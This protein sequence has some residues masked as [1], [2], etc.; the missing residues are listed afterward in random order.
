[1]LRYLRNS[2]KEKHYRNR[3]TL[4]AIYVSVDKRARLRGT[5]F[6]TKKHFFEIYAPA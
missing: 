3:V 6:Q 1:M 5:D 4:L 2:Q